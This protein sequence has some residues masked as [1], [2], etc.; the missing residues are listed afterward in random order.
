MG[1]PVYSWIWWK[2]ATERVVKTV[3]QFYL[4]CTGANMVEWVDV[5]WGVI[6]RGM[7]MMGLLSL[8]T[9]IIT[10]KWTD[11]EEDPSAVG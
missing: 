3:A 5:D 4:A 6:W 11:D 8:A 2:R 10:S 1:D 7:V 9:S